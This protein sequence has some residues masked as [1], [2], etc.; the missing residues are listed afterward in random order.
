MHRWLLLVCAVALSACAA[1][2]PARPT[3]P[4]V[5]HPPALDLFTKATARCAGLTTFTAALRLSGRAGHERLRGTLLTGLA[6]PA[7]VRFEAVAPFGQP[8]FILAGTGGR[9]TLLL[10]RDNMVL[11]DAPVPDVLERLTGLRLGP[12][13]LRLLL[14]GCL[15]LPAS[16]RTGL[17]YARDWQS[18]VVGAGTVAYLRTIDGRPR[19]VAADSGEWR[20]DYAQYQNDWPR[21]VRLRTVAGDVDITA[22]L[23]DIA[24]NTEI[25]PRAFEVT[26][27]AGAE[28]IT[29][30]H[31][32]SVVPLRAPS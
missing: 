10:P 21:Q 31:L 1:R 3:A 7:S 8:V 19:I 23:E 6:A 20:V 29:L 30:N 15:A 11:T 32:R 16:P 14:T 5:P 13:D 22:V 12:V 2:T 24:I 17:L 28:P 26:V 18:V 9:A 27:P 4:G 25:D